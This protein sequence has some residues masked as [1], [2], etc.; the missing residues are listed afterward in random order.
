[1]NTWAYLR[2]NPQY[3]ANIL[4]AYS[5]TTKNQIFIYLTRYISAKTCNVQYFFNHHHYS[6]KSRRTTWEI[7]YITC[8]SLF[9]QNFYY[10]LPQ[11]APLSVWFFGESLYVH[12]TFLMTLWSYK[13]TA[14]RTA[15]W[16]MCLPAVVNMPSGEILLIIWT[17]PITWPCVMMGILRML[18]V[19]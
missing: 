4:K 8:L 5:S 18:L 19:V 9:T 2:D 17:T 15:I 1:M 7:S 10:F 12:Y 11:V 13:A 3:T 6:P 14:N 16:Y